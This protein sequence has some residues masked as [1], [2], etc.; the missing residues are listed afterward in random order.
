MEL[1]EEQSKFIDENFHR[2]PDL[3]E[4]TR[5]VFKDGTIDGRSKE[6][7]AVRKYL[8][9]ND[10]K[11]KTTEKTK[12]KPIILNEEQK[13]FII[14]YADDGMSSFQIAQI[15]FRDREV[16]NLGMEQRTVHGYLKAAKR[17]RREAS[18]EVSSTYSPPEDSQE[19]LNLVNMY[20]SQD[21]EIKELKALEKKSIESLY[22]FLR[23]PRFN[24]IISNYGKPDDQNLFEAEF[25]RATWNKP[26]LTADE[27]NLYINVCVD[28]INLKNIGAHIEKLNRMFEDADEQ[29][30]MTVRLAELLKTKSEEYNQCE[31]RQESLI[32][33]LAGDRA[34]RVAAKQNNN[35]SILS[36][37]ESFQNEEERNLMVKMAEMQKKAIEE[38]ASE[39]ESMQEWKSRVLGISKGGAI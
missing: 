4:L 7:R 12:A 34:K 18:R 22:R 17:Q 32:Q 33:R 25:I 20:A 21:L 13:E 29:Q 28:Y 31:K 38:E 10:V 3:I 1:S 9:D 19:C 35:A 15:L 36:L 2:I 26:D 30:D 5:A 39:L 23:S 6:G 14:Q 8:S 16:K 27:V 11:Y 24:Q 37:V